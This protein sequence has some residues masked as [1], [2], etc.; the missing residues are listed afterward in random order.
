[1]FIWNV[2]FVLSFKFIYYIFIKEFSKRYNIVDKFGLRF[3]HHGKFGI[4]PVN[5]KS[6]HMEHEGHEVDCE[7]SD[8]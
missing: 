5:C 2:N 8:P 1:M 4:L 7:V 3:L 6:L